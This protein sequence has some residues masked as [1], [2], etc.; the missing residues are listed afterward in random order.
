MSARTTRIMALIRCPSRKSRS[1]RRI[2]FDGLHDRWR[3]VPRNT[4]SQN[5][6]G[7]FWSIT[8]HNAAAKAWHPPHVPKR[9]LG[10]AQSDPRREKLG[11]PERT[12]RLTIIKN[13]IP[14]HGFAFRS[15]DDRVLS[16][17]LESL[18]PRPGPG[19]PPKTRCRPTARTRSLLRRRRS[20]RRLRLSPTSR[21]AMARPRV[22]VP[23]RRRS[24]T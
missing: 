17:H 14:S 12:V 7:Q 4:L 3:A 10:G 18:N 20:P 16:R 19:I 6:I 15:V 22:R 8:G 11:N 1:L 21:P 13:G 2:A 5:L 23:R 24:P 9:D